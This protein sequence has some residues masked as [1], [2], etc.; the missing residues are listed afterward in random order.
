MSLLTVSNL[1]TTIF[2]HSERKAR[3]YSSYV[4][5]EPT[6][7]ENPP[8]IL[9]LACDPIIFR[10]VTVLILSVQID[11]SDPRWYRYLAVVILVQAITRTT[12]QLSIVVAH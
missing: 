7:I 11:S 5:Y 9:D 3:M 1:G 12:K 4:R 2:E 6:T 8:G 10:S